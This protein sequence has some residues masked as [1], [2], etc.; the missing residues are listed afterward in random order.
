MPPGQPQAACT[1]P[2]PCRTLAVFRSAATSDP[3]SR[4]AAAAGSQGEG[5]LAKALRGRAAGH[6]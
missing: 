6:Q 5:I 4:S 1:W 2:D 3:L